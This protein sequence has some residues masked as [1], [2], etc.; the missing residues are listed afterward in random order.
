VNQIES[1]VSKKSAIEMLK[2]TLDRLSI[3]FNEPNQESVKKT[4]GLLISD[5][6]TKYLPGIVVTPNARYV[7]SCR[8]SLPNDS[9]DDD[10][11]ICFEAGPRRPGQPSFRLDFNP[12]KLSAASIPNLIGLLSGWIAEDPTIFFYSG[13]ITRCDAAIDC[14]GYRNDAGAPR[15]FA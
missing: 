10:A 9:S 3:C 8:F 7:A 13:K 12:S 5:A 6:I 11:K 2:L 14:L 15:E 4:V 1:P